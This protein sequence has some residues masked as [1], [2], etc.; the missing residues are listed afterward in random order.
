MVSIKAHG[1]SGCTGQIHSSH[2]II[3][4]SRA[5][6]AELDVAAN[7]NSDF[8]GVVNKRYVLV[9]T[10][11]AGIL[12]VDREVISLVGDLDLVLQGADGDIRGTEGRAGDS[13]DLDI[14][15]LDAVVLNNSGGT[16]LKV[17]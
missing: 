8:T 6:E 4:N 14:D 5:R 9:N 12:V 10:A 11:V 2:G 16:S 13:S 15:V 17:T 1:L 7:G 3:S